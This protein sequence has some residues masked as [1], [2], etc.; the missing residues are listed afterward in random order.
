[1]AVPSSAVSVDG[2]GRVCEV[3]GRVTLREGNGQSDCISGVTVDG[4][5]KLLAALSEALNMMVL[6]DGCLGRR[7]SELLAL[8]WSDIDLVS[9]Y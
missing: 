8:K 3:V 2:N 5:G 9:R 4:F 1:M 6:V 7:I